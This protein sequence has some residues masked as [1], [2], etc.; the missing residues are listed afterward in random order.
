MPGSFCILG[1]VSS[2]QL[3]LL[4]GSRKQLRMILRGVSA[5]MVVLSPML[6]GLLFFPSFAVAW[7]MRNSYGV[8]A[9]SG[10]SARAMTRSIRVVNNGIRSLS[11]VEN[12]PRVVITGTGSVSSVGWGD[13]HFDNLLAG[14]SGLKVSS[15]GV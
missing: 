14:K 1:I 3:W 12:R 4:C 10:I 15:L 7:G 13:E 9:G 11:M 8:T 5:K 2:V 6:L